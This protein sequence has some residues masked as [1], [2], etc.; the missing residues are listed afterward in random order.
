MGS[1]ENDFDPGKGDE[2]PGETV[3]ASTDVS[4]LNEEL[5][6]FQYFL[7]TF[8]FITS[9]VLAILVTY[10]FMKA[11][12]VEA[13]LLCSMG[14]LLVWVYFAM[15]KAR[16]KFLAPEQEYRIYQNF[17]RGF[18]FLFLILTSYTVGWKGELDRVLW[19][20]IFPIAA[21]LYLGRKEGFYWAVSFLITMIFI[22]FY[23]RPGALSADAFRSFKLIYLMSFAVMCGIGIAGKYGIQFT[24]TRFINR[25][26]QL[27]ESEK[28][29]REAYEGLQREMGERRQAQHALAESEEKYRLIFENS[30]DVICSIDRELRTVDVSPS[31]KGILGYSPSELIGR[32]IRELN[33]MTPESLECA[34]SDAARVL[35]GASVQTA[36]YTFIAKDGSGHCAEVSLAPVRRGGEVVGIILV[37]RDITEQKR[38][39][40]EK[41]SL[42]ERLQHA[43]KM[44][45]I[46]TLAGGIAHDFNNLLMGI[47][48]YASLMLQ[49]L[50]PSHPHHERLKGIEEQVA[51][52]AELTS[53][54]LGFARGGRY[55][56]KPTSINDII[57]KT[58]SI[59]GR[60]QKEISI[61]RKYGENLFAVEVDQGQI[62][63][64]F[65]N[66]YVNAWQAM[67]GGGQIWLETA[68]CILDEAQAIPHAI[69]PGTYVKIMVTDT[70][71]GM[72]EKTRGRIFE[73][74][75]TTKAM[76]RGT[77][78]GLAMVY[79][80]IS[81]HGGMINV[82]SEPGQGTTFTIYLPAS[83]KKVV[84]K[85]TAA[86][87]MARGTETILLV[88]DE[89]V[90]VTVSKAMLESIGYRVFAAGSGQEAIAVYW[91]KKNEIDLVVLDM[92]MPGISGGETFDRLREI[93]SE[94]KVLLSSGYS[95][96]EEVQ[97][98]MNR[99]CNGFLQ[100]PFQLEIF[101]RK[102]R[103]MLD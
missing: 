57:E 28:K 35:G 95:L 100:K 6:S 5:F 37:A 26:A 14:L 15:R 13:V 3:S 11:Q 30:I 80:I 33:V 36:S 59:F 99:G 78:L 101:S 43:N 103:E 31:I 27:L 45:S 2:Q 12:I 52:G 94:I 41:R 92:I 97:A 8:F 54:L 83:E 62:E 56:V 16:L 79:G 22:L 9:P 4:L 64:V 32:P 18:L 75:F 48:G 42:E 10:N 71:I 65:M 87:T 82:H 58:S 51:S 44:E 46:G 7:R 73:P 63:Q 91:E 67:P 88:D 69:K 23:L 68:N 72:D 34:L 17:I 39:E 77:G 93:N 66:L 24:Y 98:I 50:D 61:H 40:E 53:Q 60:T 89:P 74:F 81:G 102:L 76:G 86:G 38:A 49:D 19:S 70:G 25:K 84:R 55:E 20:Y 47:Q 29:Y 90:N 96:N 1:A 21:F 85:G